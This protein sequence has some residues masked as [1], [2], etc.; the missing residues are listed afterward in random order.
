MDTQA[1]IEPFRG[2]L[3][4][5]ERM[6]HTSWRDEYGIS[7]FPNF[8]R[9]AYLRYLFGRL[10]DKRYLHAVYRDEEILSFIANLPRKFCFKEKIYNAVLSCILVTRKEAVRRGLAFALVKKCIDLNKEANFDFALL[11][12]EK[13]HRSTKLVKK[14]AEEGA[15]LEWVKRIRVLGRILDLARV[16][17]SEKLKGWEKTALKLW[18]GHSAPRPKPGFR[19]EEY[20]SGDLDQCLSLLN[21]YRHT[22]TLSRYWDRDELGWELEFP[23]VAKTLVHK[24]DGRVAGLISFIYHEHLGITTERWAWI[25]HVAYPDLSGPERAAFIQA[26]LQYAKDVGCVGVVEWTK[27]Y[28]PAGPLYKAKFFPYFR[29]VNMYSWTFNPEISLKN[30]PDVYEVQI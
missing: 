30:I 13:G 5:L 12:L 29:S 11:T 9:P 26:F 3:E 8:Y 24:K 7:S 15:P 10:P 25:N 28:Y 16:C 1:T 27:K 14:L 17:R 22:V 2:D 6:A 21:A 20:T 4:N 23:E 18:G 19:L